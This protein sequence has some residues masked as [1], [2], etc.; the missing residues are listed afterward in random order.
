MPCIEQVWPKGTRFKP[1]DQTFPMRREPRRASVRTALPS[2]PWDAVA[3]APALGA[4]EA[5]KELK[6][7]RFWP[8]DA[9]RLP[10]YNCSSPLACAWSID[11]L[12]IGA[13][14]S[15]AQSIGVAYRIYQGQE[16]GGARGRRAD[17]WFSW[18]KVSSSVSPDETHRR[19]LTE[20]VG[21]PEGRPTWTRSKLQR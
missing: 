17:D 18:M 19:G 3:V 15:V 12:W 11:T 13:R 16:R 21:R 4:C 6:D 14:A 2:G 1:R 8:L 20:K 7:Q 10:L 5:A 9:P